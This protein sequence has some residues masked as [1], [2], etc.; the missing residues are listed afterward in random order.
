MHTF[1]H[2]GFRIIHNG[3]FSGD[4]IIRHDETEH[5]ITVPCKV[6]FGFALVA[7]GQKQTN[8]LAAVRAEIALVSGVVQALA[9]DMGCPEFATGEWREQ[10]KRLVRLLAQER[11]LMGDK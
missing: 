7:T 9:S 3:D 4:A 11:E 6:L 10:K 5:E 1:E 2:D 8:T